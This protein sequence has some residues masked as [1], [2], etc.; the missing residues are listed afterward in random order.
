MTRFG[1]QDLFVNAMQAS[2]VCLLTLFAASGVYAQTLGL[3]HPAPSPDGSK[4]C[5]GYEGDLWVVSSRGGNATRLTVH[6]GYE[7]FPVWSP[8][9]KS[10]AFSSD[11]NGNFDVFTIAATGGK[12][13]RLTW[14][15]NDDFVSG[16]SPDSRR[17]LFH[18]RRD[19]SFEQVWE[20][21]ATG[22]REKPLTQIASAYG[23]KTPD[24]EKLI[25]VRGA[26]P[27]WRKGYRGGANCDIY[28]KNLKSG[29]IEQLTFFA[30]NDLYGSIVPG[31]AELIYLS[32]ST[33]N[34]NLFR[35]NLIGGT[36]VQMTNHRL[37]V[38]HPAL[39]ADGSLIAY[40]LAGE[41][42]LYDLKS[43]Q[44]RK[45][46]VEAISSAKIN[47][48]TF[49][50]A[51]SGISEF[52]LAPDGNSL[53][54]VVGG[55]VF[56]RSLGD[57]D[58]RRLITSVAVEHD[59]FWAV[60]S[61]QLA[62][63][64]RKDGA[65]T[66]LLLSSN[67]SQRP[68]LQNSHDLDIQTPIKSQQSLRS[69]QI[70]PTMARI[71]FIRGEV[72]LVVADLSK[73][74]ERTIA[75]KNHIG[76]FSWSPDGR[77]IVFTQRDGNWDNELFIGDSESGSV[78]KISAVPG[79]YRDP[80]F[81][82][83][84]KMIYYIEDGDVYYFYLDRQVSEMSHSQRRD[85]LISSSRPSS[86]TASPVTIDFEAIA[87][88]VRRL[89]ESGNVVSLAMTP[90]SDGFV[91][92]TTD[93]KVLHQHI[94]EAK[95][96]LLTDVISRPQGLQFRGESNEFVLIDAAG[97]L[98]S[99]DADAGT[100]H[101]IGFRAEW[102]VSRSEL[103]RQIFDDVW[104]E[105]KNRFYDNTMHGTNWESLR[106]TYRSQVA[107]RSEL[108]DFHDLLREML[109]QVNASHLN[110]WPNHNGNR[111]TGMIGV[112][113]DYEDNASGVI[114][115][116]VLPN[117]PASRKASEIRPLDKVTAIGGAKLESTTNYF[118]PLEGLTD[119]EVKVDLINRGGI[120]RSVYLSPISQDEYHELTWHFREA[121]SKSA[122]DK[123]S[124][125]QIGYIALQQIS[126]ASV[127]QF[128][129]AIK[130]L[131]Q[132]KRALVIDVRGNSGGAE[133]DRLLSILS[134]KPYVKHTP[135]LGTGGSDSPWAFAGP[136]ALLVDE[137]TSSDAEI[138]AQGFKELGL[139]EVIGVATYGAVIGTEKK[140]MADGS[141][142]S[143]P[144][145]GW[146]TMSDKN[147]EN[148]GVAPDHHVVL[149]LNK[150]DRG[151]DNQ[152]SEAVSRLM[153]KL[154]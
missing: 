143:V 42:Y 108:V 23:N 64:S 144:T 57:D 111:E 126:A 44:G 116:E 33:G 125:N 149:D 117:S 19:Q 81:S 113:P 121:K 28:S 94:D 79:W 131:S 46:L 20:I 26:V 27:W 122:V 124:Q 135:R 6:V 115:L 136:I 151:E 87:N 104:S 40:E 134:R 93:D 38:H 37:D 11:R 107:T 86:R 50:S 103:Y 142:L 56:C 49:F 85:Y 100:T 123:Q 8:D 61:R 78:V 30:G 99:I 153:A 82:S 129:D 130:V 105:I 58:Q 114:V 83:D 71:A 128:E 24:N 127:A 36:V 118:A 70:S 1:A 145:V 120:N 17:V 7:S 12:E 73:L 4:I 32:D 95:P 98:F 39:S 53:A 75:D 109:G 84:G 148:L 51:D 106:E 147:L 43:L 88:R 2:L 110:I 48:F 65:N 101:R 18:S 47:D 97:R 34:Y 35:R 41:I 72:Q 139:G 90:N 15:S 74:T 62:I 25:F 59:L 13:T 76:D 69:P 21:P 154:R 91:F 66:I 55:E 96:R 5:F 31:S 10:I 132:T 22:G 92:T 133:H 29:N 137:Y 140:I 150:A 141:V 102:S 63:V 112:I 60:D 119:Q 9:G 54:F 45:L 14:H 138:V 67:D 80:R 152:L 146:S 77:Y 52:V 89:T 16:W 3:R 68:L